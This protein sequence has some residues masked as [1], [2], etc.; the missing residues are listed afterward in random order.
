MKKNFP[1]TSQEIEVPEGISLVSKTDLKGILTYANN[2]FV[3]ISGY[4][5][6]ELLGKS[7]N[8]VRHPDM[9]EAVFKDM[10]ATLRSGKPWQG[11][12]KNRCKNGDFYWVEACVVPIRRNEQTIGYMS[13]RQRTKPE[14]VAAVQKLY[15]RVAAQGMPRILKMPSWVGIRFG[16]RAGTVFV[17]LMM[18]A[19]GALGIG[20]LKLAD[21]AFTRMYQEQF[22]PVTAVGQIEAQLNA[23]R[24]SMLESQLS[25]DNQIPT[26]RATSYVEQL[27]GHYDEI[28]E[29]S[30]KLDGAA[31]A[32]SASNA[33]L[34]Q[35]L[36]RYI[37]EGRKIV[38]QASVGDAATASLS[39]A[40][41]NQLLDLER[42]ASLTAQAL[43]QSLSNAAQQ[44]FAQ[45]LERNASIRQ[46]A[47]VG[48]ALGLL[49]VA[50]V[51]RL[52]ISGI[53][54]PLNASIRQLN[55]IAEGDLQGKIELSGTGETAQLNH[56]SAVM[57]LHLKV[58]LDE[59]ALAA[60]SIHR[61]CKKLNA[62]LYEVTEHSE[63]QHDQVYSAIRALD[64]ATA[65]T[66][67]LSERAERLLN[68]AQA[69]D[70]T[71]SHE[72]RDLA[73][74]TRLS[75]FGAEEVAASMHQVASLIVENRGEAQLAWQ[76]S[77]ELMHTARELNNLV[78]FFEPEKQEA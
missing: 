19:G 27:Q 63:A 29:I 57:Q 10:W 11:L 42:K 35:A 78:D 12:I 49:I 58:M 32:A 24:A 62:A 74:A 26:G 34:T 3:E 50:V 21:A 70:E 47:V 51:G 52:F 5:Q 45:T 54:N 14:A 77:E 73:T 39:P 30:D 61:H 71:L 9:P 66:R 37:E 28:D 17:A 2:A 44:E 76:A 65:E 40:T 15:E 64:A 59:I 7:H 67:D 53:V 18:L 31:L 23:L 22:E 25:R 55:R 72:I 38:H 69:P 46:F 13:V 8:I 20:G 56:A 4:E 68:M 60:R 41:F 36:Q 43:R 6:E 33:P 48:I 75:A 16:M 1:V